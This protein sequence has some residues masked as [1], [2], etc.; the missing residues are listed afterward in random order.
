M[1]RPMAE[2]P[3][4]RASL[5]EAVTAWSGFS[6]ARASELEEF[7]LRIVGTAP[8]KLS[9]PASIMPSGAA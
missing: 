5:T 3:S 7:T 4:L 8:A 6:L 2:Q 1:V 9:A